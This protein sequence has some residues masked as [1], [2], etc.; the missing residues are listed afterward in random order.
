MN[1]LISIVAHWTVSRTY[2][3][4]TLWSS[5]YR[6]HTKQ[7]A[8]SIT[9]ETAF[10]AQPALA[11]HWLLAQLIC[12]GFAVAG[13]ALRY[14]SGRYTRNRFTAILA[15]SKTRGMANHGRDRRGRPVITMARI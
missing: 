9:L 13:V 11:V 7:A 4:V 12:R 8:N 3:W 2:V 6:V 1:Y 14:S 5:V 15:A 10:G